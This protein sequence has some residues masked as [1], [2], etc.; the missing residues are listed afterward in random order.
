MRK[1]FGRTLSFATAACARKIRSCGVR[2]NWYL[3]RNVKLMLDY[4]QSDSEAAAPLPPGHCEDE[5]VIISRN[6]G[7]V[8]RPDPCS[9]LD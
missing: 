4:D 8:L 3:N 1:L 6:P 9:A 7:L 5:K 2:A